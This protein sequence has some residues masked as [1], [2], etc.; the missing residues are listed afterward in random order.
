MLSNLALGKAGELRVASE[1]LLRG[2]EVYFA[3]VDGGTDLILATGKRIQ[4]KAAKKRTNENHRTAYYFS[5]KSWRKKENKHTKHELIGIDYVILWGI[6]EDIFLIIPTEE[7]R[8]HYCVRF[9]PNNKR[10]HNKTSNYLQY[11]NRWDLLDK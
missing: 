2:Q 11:I 9:A 5:F 6:D 8:G 3:V 4:V 10:P 1:L 7:V